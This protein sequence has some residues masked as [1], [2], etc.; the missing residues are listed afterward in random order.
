MLQ[1]RVDRPCQ[2]DLLEVAPLADHLV[3][4]VL[5]AHRCHVLRNDRTGVEIRRDV[6]ARGADDFY[7]ARESRVIRL[8]SRECR[9]ERVV[10]VDHAFRHG[11]DEVRRQ[12]LHVTGEHDQ[13]DVL[14][15]QQG[16]LAG[17]GLHFRC[18]S[19]RNVL[20]PNTET[21]RDVLEVRVVADD[22]RNVH[23]PL[24]GLPAGEEVIQAMAVLR[25]EDRQTQAPA[26][27]LQ[28][29]THVVWPGHFGGEVPLE[30][31]DGVWVGRR[32]PLDPH[33]EHAALG[34]H[35]LVQVHDVAV[36]LADEGGH[37]GDQAF[38][39]GAVDEQYQVSVHAGR[40]VEGTLSG[41]GTLKPGVSVPSPESVP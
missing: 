29:P 39:V 19:D 15:A 30:K 20:E 10:D 23:G 7:A 41:E 28:P 24:S 5:V 2:H 6:V 40:I 13:V 3:D 21:A 33:E 18:A 12:D 25:D 36:G 32:R 11:F 1:V 27:M 31:L 37:R 14:L 22:D 4:R 38:A 9:Q 8:P 17:F 34:V 26:C 35:V 16:E